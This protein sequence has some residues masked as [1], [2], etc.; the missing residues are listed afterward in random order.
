MSLFLFFSHIPTV[1]EVVPETAAHDKKPRVSIP[2]SEKEERVFAFAGSSPEGGAVWERGAQE[3]E[4]QP[5][6]T[7]GGP[8]EQGEIRPALPSQYRHMCTCWKSF[9]LQWVS[10]LSLQNTVLKATAPKRRAVCLM[11]VVVFLVLNVAPMR[12]AWDTE[13][14]NAFTCHKKSFDTVID[15]W[16][17]IQTKWVL[18]TLILSGCMNISAMIIDWIEMGSP[19][20]HS[21][22]HAL[23]V[24]YYAK[25]VF[26]FRRCLQLFNCPTPSK[27]RKISFIKYI[28]QKVKGD[29][30]LS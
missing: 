5:K 18:M 13:Q 15:G 11:V 17:S 22:K 23:H 27:R 28:E 29:H 6:E 25:N 24:R 12:W 16:N 19:V 8:S 14:M 7:A 1:V 4:R 30:R 20:T 2:V 21:G 26:L 10:S 9:L 3:W